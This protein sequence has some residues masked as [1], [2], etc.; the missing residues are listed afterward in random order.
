MQY[1]KSTEQRQRM[2]KNKHFVKCG[3]MIRMNCT[4]IGGQGT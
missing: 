1:D 3:E 4:L 2:N